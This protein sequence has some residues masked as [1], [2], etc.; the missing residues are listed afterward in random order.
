[1]I[2]FKLIVTVQK[3][4]LHRFDNAENFARNVPRRNEIGI[5]AAVAKRGFAAVRRKNERA[6]RIRPRGLLETSVRVS[7]GVTV[8]QVLRNGVFGVIL[9]LEIELRL[10]FRR[11]TLEFITFFAGGEFLAG[12]PFGEKVF[13]P[14]PLTA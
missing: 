14:L 7:D 4:P 5:F 13:F 3:R 1:M 9:I 6:E 10:L 2:Y 11:K 12:I 8:F